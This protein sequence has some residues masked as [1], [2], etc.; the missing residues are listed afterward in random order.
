MQTTVTITLR[1]AAIMVFLNELARRDALTEHLLV[2][3]R[4]AY[5][6]RGEVRNHVAE[7]PGLPSQP[8][9]RENARSAAQS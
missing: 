4:V 8:L 6:T 3:D 5:V 7:L 9:D 1:H 2:Q